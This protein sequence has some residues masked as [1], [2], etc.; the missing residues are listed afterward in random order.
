MA[1]HKQL[2]SRAT[3]DSSEVSLAFS[4]D[5][6]R[7]ALIDQEAAPLI[8]RASDGAELARLAEPPGTV[9]NLAFS[10]DGHWLAVVAWRG[11]VLYDLAT[12]TILPNTLQDGIYVTWAD[13]DTLLI[14]T[15]ESVLRGQ[16]R[17]YGLAY[18]PQRPA[19]SADRR[20]P[21]PAPARRRRLVI[22]SHWSYHL[23]GNENHRPVLPRRHD[24]APAAPRQRAPG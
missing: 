8:L 22:S 23:Q 16:G 13:D 5:G 24:S 18:R 20:P 15:M 7:L 10:P 12:G 21:T 17:R 14:K 4:P 1:S 11:I 6:S 3:G 19:G 2:W 9:N